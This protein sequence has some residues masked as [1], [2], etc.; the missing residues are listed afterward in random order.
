MEEFTLQLGCPARLCPPHQGH[1]HLQVKHKSLTETTVGR[2]GVQLGQGSPRCQPPTPLHPC[3]PPLL[4]HL[5]PTPPAP[6]HRPD[7]SHPSNDAQQGESPEQLRSLHGPEAAP[8]ASAKHPLHPC[9]APQRRWGW[10]RSQGAVPGARPSGQLNS[11]RC[12][13]LQ[14]RRME[15]EGSGEPGQGAPVPP[16]PPSQHTR[17]LPGAWRAPGRLSPRMLCLQ[18][19]QVCCRRSQG[20]T[21]SR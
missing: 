17:R 10:P 12:S 14:G 7:P 13:S 20:S 11:P 2:E 21:Q 3:V 5:A 4:P 9:L 19:G 16:Q 18:R 1:W 8:A 6:W 15:G